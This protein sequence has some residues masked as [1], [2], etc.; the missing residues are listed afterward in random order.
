MNKIAVA[1]L[2]CL[3]IG[4]I[5]LDLSAQSKRKK[6]NKPV[7][8]VVKDT[9]VPKIQPYEKLLKDPQKLAKG[10]MNL[11]YQKGKLYLEIPMALMNRDML[12]ASTIS[13]IS[14][15]YDG[16]VGSKPTDPLLVTFSL[17]DSTVLLR[18][19]SKTTIAPASDSNILAALE[20]NSIGAIMK[21]FPVAAFKSDRSTA[22]IDVTDYFLG[23]IK[24]IS[25][26][27]GFSMYA[28]MGLQGTQSF[29]KDRSFI[30]DIKAFEDNIIIKSHLSY[31]NSLSNGRAT[32]EKDRP[33][34]AV[35]SRTLL[36]LP[37]Q[38][39]RPRIA[40]SRIG[41]FNT[42]KSS[43]S[44]ES[45]RTD[46]VYYAHRFRLEPKDVA[47]WKRGELVEP[48]KPIVFYVDSDF[49]QSWKQPIKEAIED[50]NLAFEKI[51]FKK[52]VV[53]K[54]Y[55]VN[56][57]AF[58]PD[59]LVYNCIRYAPVPVAN[60]MG[61]SW[62]DP[63]SGE[64]INASVYVF[65]DIVKLLN[66]WMFVQTAPADKAVRQ[67][68]MPE[69]HKRDG[70]KYV[71]RHELGH[72][73]GFMHNMGA[74]SSIPVDSLRS[75]SFTQAHGTTYS[76]MDYA[77][78]NYVAQPGDLEKGV[79]LTP[80]VF[81]EYDYYAVKW[82][83]TY[84]DESV[85]AKEEEKTLARMIAEKAGDPRY[86]YG[87]QQSGVIDPAAQ[88]EDLGNDAVK[89][90]LL[91]IKNLKY[92]VQNLNSW[93]GQEDKDYTYRK[94]IWE[95]IVQQ[96]V[97]Y[98]NHVYA[99]IG[100]FYLYEKYVGDP[101]P[102]HEPVPRKK[103]QQALQ[104][105]LKEISNLDWIEDSKILQHM[106]LT[107][108]PATVLRNQLMQALLQSPAK[109]H[110]SALK[111]TETKPY[112]PAEAMEEVYAAVWNATIKKG[113][114]SKSARDNQKAWVQYTLKNAKLEAPGA[115]A[116]NAVAADLFTM[117][118]PPSFIKPPATLACEHQGAAGS[119]APGE[120]SPLAAF[121]GRSINFSLQPSFETIYFSYL[122]RVRSLLR[123]S[124]QT[125]TDKETL[126]HYKLLLHQIEKALK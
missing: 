126:I 11:Y 24:D 26:F 108:T 99:N 49:P 103:Q 98:I 63:R 60:A 31:E 58:D 52:A 27:G 32:L 68:T 64:I 56:D 111:S 85:S 3:L 112:T 105:L 47:A 46:A 9:V 19:L 80:P 50:W 72:C 28:A 62:V 95:G 94:Q 100:G 97:R 42:K 81:G 69:S 17:V 71:L 79:R 36:L 18:K 120:A 101:G 13:E 70:L 91:G 2:S 88:T 38:P 30:G 10:M 40:D 45:N 16:I 59:N 96:Y 115:G 7:A 35:M 109:L 23:D 82:N 104:F 20:K 122:T 37:G 55:P 90:S 51:G 53:A 124:V 92:I 4:G 76:I 6:K 65:H 43:L 12:L 113:A 123:T 125:T 116:A 83:Y 102:L 114:V 61:P 118:T 8:A 44:N 67:V 78:Y 84:F 48:A 93:V 39:I 89:A 107:G 57:P 29:K 54:D 75:P 34:T 33:F 87:A 121:G 86:R 15:N 74:S 77:R 66:N 110:L 5:S 73:L 119:L 1:C 41:I 22:V 14:D 117:V 25:P 106:A 21:I